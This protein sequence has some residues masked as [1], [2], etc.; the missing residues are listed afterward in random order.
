MLSVDLATLLR[1]GPSVLFLI[2]GLLIT[3]LYADNRAFSLA[4]RNSGLATH[5]R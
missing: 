2:F 3:G 5:E 1:M 4:L